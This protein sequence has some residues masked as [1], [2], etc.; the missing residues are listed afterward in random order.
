LARQRT[1][2]EGLN[3]QLSAIARRDALT[4]LGNRRAL[5]EDLEVLEGRVSRYGHRYCMALLD[6]D[7]FK[8]YND[9][10]GHPAGDEALQFVAKQLKEQAR[11]GDTLYRYGGEE[12]VWIFPEQ[13]LPNATLAVER[14]RTGLEHSAIPHTACP[15]GVLTISAGLAMLEPHQPRSANDVLKEADEALYRAKRLG[16]NRVEQMTARAT[17]A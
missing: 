10:Y 17:V 6:I 9:T 5:Q 4:A 1:Q 14:M 16:R 13:S 15:L 8:L 12:F 3:F 7:Y 2:L 11:G